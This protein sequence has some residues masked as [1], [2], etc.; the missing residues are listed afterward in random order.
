MLPDTV[1]SPDIPVYRGAT[2]ALVV[3]YNNLDNYHGVDGFNDVHF[4]EEPDVSR[5]KEEMAASVISKLAKYLF[6]NILQTLCVSCLDST[7]E[8]L[9]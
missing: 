8:R 5:V 2:E 3:P 4:D 9:I 7:L 6:S 1:G